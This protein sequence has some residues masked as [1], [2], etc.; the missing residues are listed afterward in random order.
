MSK[1]KVNE[2]ESVGGRAVELTQGVTVTGNATG[3]GNLTANGHILGDGSTDIGNGSDAN[4]HDIHAD[5][6]LSCVGVTATGTIT[7]NV[8]ETDEGSIDNA[9]LFEGVRG[10]FHDGSDAIS[11][12]SGGVRVQSNL[13]VLGSLGTSA[14]ALVV[15]QGIVNASNSTVKI[16]E[17]VVNGDTYTQSDFQ[18]FSGA[19]GGSGTNNVKASGEYEVQVTSTIAADGTIT[20]SFSEDPDP[21]AQRNMSITRD[22]GDGSLDVTLTPALDSTGY[23]VHVSGPYCQVTSKAVGGFTLQPKQEVHIPAP[24]ALTTS[25]VTDDISLSILVLEF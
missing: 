15:D 13:T 19:S 3:S 11:A 25:V 14:D 16:Q 2:I 9:G 7:G 12:P 4:V 18:N 21:K 8:I 23:H 17:L 10:K 5:G 6:D 20:R 22:S 24:G 1:L